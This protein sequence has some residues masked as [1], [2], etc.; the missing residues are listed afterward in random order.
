MKITAEELATLLELLGITEDH[1]VNCEE[2]LSLLP[3]YLERLRDKQE[4]AREHRIVKQHLTICPECR[5]EYEGLKDA[6]DEGLL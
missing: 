2:F 5:E 1:E 4:L 3:G 6:V